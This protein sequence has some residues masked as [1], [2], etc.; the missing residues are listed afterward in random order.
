MAHYNKGRNS[1]G[2]NS[3]KKSS[4][5]SFSNDR[6]GNR[7]FGSGRDGDRPEMHSAKCSECGNACEVPFRPTGEKPVY[8]SDCFRSRNSENSRESRDGGRKY[9]GDRDSKPRFGEKPSYQHSESKSPENYKA[10]FENL[11]NKLD[12]ILRVLNPVAAEYTKETDTPRAEQHQK[13]PKK[14][15]DTAGLKKT[16]A[17]A[18]PKKSAAKKGT[19]KKKATKKK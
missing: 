19:T 9:S 13:A 3:Y 17:K 7:G 6:G 14:E 1:N 5:R 2:G 11:N 4:E 15:I 16:I 8:C 10:Q 18:V 12:K